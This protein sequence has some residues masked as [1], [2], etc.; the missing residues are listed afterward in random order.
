[1]NRS[2]LADLFFPL[3]VIILAFQPQAEQ[4]LLSLTNSSTEVNLNVNAHSTLNAVKFVQTATHNF[5]IKLYLPQTLKPSSLSPA[6]KQRNLSSHTVIINQ[7]LFTEFALVKYIFNHH[8]QTACV[9]LACGSLPIRKLCAD[10]SS[11]QNAHKLQRQKHH[12]GLHE[13]HQHL[14]WRVETVSALRPTLLI[15]NAA[16][17]FERQLAVP[18]GR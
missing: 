16:Y 14:S 17:N 11:S 7:K 13:K 10:A 6:P 4:L 2:Y 1:M 9:S 18:V 3:R 5:P 15:N 8:P 12:N